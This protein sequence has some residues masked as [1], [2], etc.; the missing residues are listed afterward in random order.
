MSRVAVLG[1]GAGGRSAAVELTQGGHD[2]ALWNRSPA[3]LEP[4]LA[5]GVLRHRGVLGDGSVRPALLT[6]RLTDALA[7]A[8]VAVVCLPALAH[9]GLFADLASLHVTIPLVLNPGQTGGALHARAVFCRHGVPMP[10]TVELSTLTYVARVSADGAVNTTS[11]ART[12]RAGCLPGHDVARDWALRLF[13]C[14][15]SV[16]D[17]IASSLANVNIVLHPPAAVLAVAWVEATRGDFR[18][19][20]DAMTPGVTRVLEALDAE[21]LAVAAAFDVDLPT[22]TLEMAAIGTVDAA[23]AA[24]GDVRAAIRGGA[25]NAA[26]AAPSSLE[27]RYYREDLA[28]GLKP[29]LALASVARVEVPVAS[30]L[31]AL[32]SVAASIAPTA[33]LDG[34]RLAIDQFTLDGLC[35]LVRG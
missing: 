24:A 5:D 26:I 13:P 34:R 21:R 3:T 29:F 1:A 6:T 22:L 30:A 31:L 32:G 8:E 16:R 4:L 14:C 7:G 19:Y 23:A 2:V 28:F 10:P 20:V 27:H 35:R 11:R 17:V 18:F 33:G 25:A 15:V 12:V 9:E